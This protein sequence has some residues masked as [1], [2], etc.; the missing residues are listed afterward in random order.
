MGA[1][2]THARLEL[3]G[4][5]H[6]RHEASI[7][8]SSCII[9]SQ[10][11]NTPKEN[12][13]LIRSSSH[14]SIPCSAAARPERWPHRHREAVPPPL[15]ST[16]SVAS[17]RFH[18]STAPPAALVHSPRRLLKPLESTRPPS[19]GAAAGVHGWETGRRRKNRISPPPT[20]T[21]TLVLHNLV[22]GAAV[23]PRRQIEPAEV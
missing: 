3:D 6:D 8:R 19:A 11:E 1:G 13:L 20:I 23:S 7:S 21:W 12:T 2:H 5:L 15:E 17:A 10:K 14:T 16:R 4:S 22:A 18:T 9:I